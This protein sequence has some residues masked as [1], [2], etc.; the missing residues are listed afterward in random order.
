M[1]TVI[2]IIFSALLFT[3]S[4]FGY[5]DFTLNDLYKN[6]SQIVDKQIYTVCYDYKNKGARYVSYTIDGDLVNKNN[7][8]ERFRF[9]SESL[10]PKRYGS[11]YADFSHSGFDRGHLMSDASADYDEKALRKT[12]SMVNIVPMAPLVNRKTWVKV[13]ELERLVAT[14]LKSVKVLNGVEYG[15][16]PQRIGTNKISVPTAFWK[17]I[18]NKEATYQKCFYYKNTNDIDVSSDRLKDHEVECSTLLNK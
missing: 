16:N 15:D 6:C 1:K 13:E 10:I 2:K 12:Y 5:T 18:Y 17:M 14:K 11:K 4:A 8:E 3:V 9:Y 7:I